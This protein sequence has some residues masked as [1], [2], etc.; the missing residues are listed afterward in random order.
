MK[1]LNIKS[2]FALLCLSVIAFFALD[3]LIFRSGFYASYLS[4]PGGM[5]A[6]IKIKYAKEHENTKN[7][8]I[9]IPSASLMKAGFRLNDFEKANPEAPFTIIPLFLSGSAAYTHYHLLKTIDPTHNRY[10]T[11]IL[12]SESYKIL[13]NFDPGDD[14]EYEE[15]LEI[16]SFIKPQE[17]PA[18]LKTYKGSELFYKLSMACI[19]A[20]R[21]YINDLDR[22]IPSRRFSQNLHSD[23]ENYHKLYAGTS[24]T[25]TI[26]GV[27]LGPNNEIIYCPLG[28]FCETHLRQSTP[29]L[30][31]VQKEV[32][33]KKI[34]AYEKTWLTKILELYK[35]SSTQLV[36][37]QMPRAFYNDS[38]KPLSTAPD[39]KNILPKQH[40]VHFIDEHYFDQL[41]DF[42]YM[43]D[44]QHLNK[45]GSEVFTKRLTSLLYQCVQEKPIS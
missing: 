45:Q 24:D 5:T 6:P 44:Y 27:K 31:E 19:F 32:L 3:I 12:P 1:K 2:P 10:H 41:N 29:L 42:Q 13:S 4:D 16:I 23:D 7:P 11:I 38:R 28:A 33:S 43:K 26:L 21:T 25:H 9:L 22:F 40:N 36:F 18:F 34:L 15:A 8:L 30:P 14:T 37:I 17:C 39:L 35:D 20:N